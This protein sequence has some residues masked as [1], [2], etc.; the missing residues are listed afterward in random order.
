MP[1]SNSIYCHNSKMQHLWEMLICCQCWPPNA[2]PYVSQ[3]GRTERT[4]ILFRELKFPKGKIH[5]RSVLLLHLPFGVVSPNLEFGENFRNWIALQVGLQGLVCRCREGDGQSHFCQR[6]CQFC[7]K[8]MK[9]KIPV[10]KG[11]Q[12]WLSLLCVNP[13]PIS[14]CLR[15]QDKILHVNVCPC[16]EHEE[17]HHFTTYRH[18]N[19]E[20]RIKYS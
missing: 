13:Q 7:R 11:M 19:F 5:D 9:A 17:I 20:S 8:E 15:N 12:V 1:R 18:S 3:L 2:G 14:F 4:K 16:H 10:N 6:K